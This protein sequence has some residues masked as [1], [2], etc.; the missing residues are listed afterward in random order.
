MARLSPR[1]RRFL[2]ALPLAGAGVA[3]AGSGDPVSLP[4]PVTGTSVWT[5]PGLELQYTLQPGADGRP[6]S[7]VL[8]SVVD[9]GGPRLRT[10]L[11]IDPTHADTTTRVSPL[12]LSLELPTA[13]P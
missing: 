4:G 8:R 7:S 5:A 12:D 10:D 13:G 9:V 6:V 3:R 1:L 11:R 2:L